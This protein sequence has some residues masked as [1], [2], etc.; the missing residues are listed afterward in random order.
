MDG[1]DRALKKLWMPMYAAVLC[2]GAA[3]AAAVWNLGAFGLGIALLVAIGGA[4]VAALILFMAEALGKASVFWRVLVATS[5][6]GGVAALL[7]VLLTIVF[8][9]VFVLARLIF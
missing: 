5:A 8:W 2:A 7:F 6:I 3:A 4:A 1:F 9:F